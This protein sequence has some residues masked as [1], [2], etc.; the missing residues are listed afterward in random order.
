MTSGMTSKT[1]L[2]FFGTEDFSL[3]ALQALVEAGYNI[4]AVVTKP[5]TPRGR[6]HVLTPPSV[7]VYAQEHAIPVWQ[8]TK[9]SEIADDITA[10]QPVAG[11]LVSYGKIIPQSII[12]LF[13]PGIINVH[14]S[15]LPLYRG[16]SPIE[17]A[18][19]NR[20]SQTGVSIMQLSAKMDAGPV[21]AQATHQLDGTE[22]QTSAYQSLVKI[23]VQLLISTL[24]AILSGELQPT[25][26]DD[27]QATYCQLL[28]KEQSW[29]DPASQTAAQVEAMIR[30]HQVFPRTRYN[31]NGQ[32]LIITAAHVATAAQ[33]P[34][35]ITFHDGS[36]L[37]IDRLIAPSG[38]QMSASDYLRGHRS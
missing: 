38:K 27:S 21:Y 9:L 24:P 32:N 2:I 13:T 37:G 6:G 29:I 15:L 12:D 35:D 33:N 19:A 10:L 1:K 5:D 20:D 31:H 25:D 28:T 34:L 30:A 11:V 16:P 23:G 8:P 36:V 7:K 18:I 26:Q 4:A 3:A 14:P 17:A 22:T